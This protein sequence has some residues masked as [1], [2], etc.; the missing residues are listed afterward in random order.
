[1]TKFSKPKKFDTNLIVIGAGAAGL[2]SSYIAAALKARVTLIESNKMG[3]DCLNTGCVP[4]KALIKVARLAHE[5][6]QAKHFGLDVSAPEV[7][8]ERVMAY[9]KQAVATIEPHDSVARYESLGVDCVAGKARLISPYVVAVNDRQI[10]APN[11]ILATGAEPRVPAIEGIADVDYLT[12]DSLW[13]LSRQPKRMLLIGGGPIGC[14]LAQSFARLGTKVTLIQRNS[15]LLVKEEEAV[16]SLIQACFQDEGV[17]LLL[18]SE[19]LSVRQENDEKIVTYG[20]QGDTKEVRGDALLIAVGRQARIEGYGL[21]TLGIQLTKSGTIHGNAFLQTSQP[22]IFVCGDAVGPYQFTHMASHQAW[23]AAV[24]ALF[25][26]VKKLK[27]DYSIVPKVTFTDPEVAS[28]GH[29]TQEADAQGIKYDINRYDLKELDRA[30]TE[31]Q[32]QGFVQV[33]TAKGKDKIIGATIVG[34]HAGELLPEIVLAMKHGLGLNKILGTIHAYPTWCEAN[35][36][37]AGNWRK[38]NKPDWLL[39]ALDTGFKWLT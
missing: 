35:K 24:N 22:N 21:E 29:S 36:F 30:I 31:G 27:V 8:F 33:L 28:V 5:I 39:G 38:A 23:Y 25:G 2:V 11:I 12:S 16:S 4:S 18:D 1:M 13:S 7:E 14:E 17:E 20:K 3:G 37:V 15:R 34:Q 9:V 26:R 10:S 32:T 19:V 6:R